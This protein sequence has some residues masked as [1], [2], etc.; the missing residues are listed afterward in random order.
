M[1][2]KCRVVIGQYFGKDEEEGGS[3]WLVPFTSLGWDG[4]IPLF[5]S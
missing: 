2:D 4:D 1:L 3:K 5:N